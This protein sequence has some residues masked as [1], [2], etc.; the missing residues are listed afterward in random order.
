MVPKACGA[1]AGGARDFGGFGDAGGS[2]GGG[3]FEDIFSQFFGGGGGG[4]QPECTATG[5]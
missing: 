3:G 2:F 5:T 4:G 1:G